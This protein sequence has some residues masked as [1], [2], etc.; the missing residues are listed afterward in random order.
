MLLL[1]GA[2]IND[3]YTGQF[4]MDLPM[5]LSEIARVE[6]LHGPTVN[7]STRD[8]YDPVYGVEPA[9]RCV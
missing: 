1:D 4:L 9:R 2:R 6:V 8:D 5:L 3:P 7:R